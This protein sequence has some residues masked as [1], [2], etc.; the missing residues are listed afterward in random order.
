MPSPTLSP[1]PQNSAS[2][3][4]VPASGK[5]PSVP[6]QLSLDSA[7]ID[8][9][10]ASGNYAHTVRVYSSKGKLYFRYTAN[11]GHDVIFDIHIPGGNVRNPIAKYRAAQVRTWIAHGLPPELISENI[12]NWRA[13]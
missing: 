2:P 1:I 8:Q 4:P 7:S 3:T 10:V 5:T 12:Q 11:V 6:R 13:K 9:P